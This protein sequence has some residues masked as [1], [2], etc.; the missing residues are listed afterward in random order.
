VPLSAPKRCT[1]SLPL[2]S[3]TG[4]ARSG[5]LGEASLPTT[6]GDAKEKVAA[7]TTHCRVSSDSAPKRCA[8]SKHSA[9]LVRLG[10]Q[11]TVTVFHRMC[12]DR[13]MREISC[14]RQAM[15]STAA[16]GKAVT[17][18]RT[19]KRSGALGQSTLPR[20]RIAGRPTTATTGPVVLQFG[21]SADNGG[22]RRPGTAATTK[23][24]EEKS[25]AGTGFFIEKS[26]FTKRT[27]LKNAE[28]FRHECVRKNESWVRFAKKSLKMG[29]KHQNTAPEGWFLRTYEAN[30]RYR[31]GST[32]R[33]ETA[34][35]SETLRARSIA[36]YKTT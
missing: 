12:Q 4:R 11:S 14:D 25:L 32:R 22:G 33:E 30:F 13:S 23:R 2:G 18:H 36:P 17:S 7:T 20:L 34:G 24:G 3:A 28:L 1:R 27:Q 29:K 8:D 5:R 19:P 10:S 16:N 9:R 31:M 15:A 26:V 6:G 35:Y 21:D